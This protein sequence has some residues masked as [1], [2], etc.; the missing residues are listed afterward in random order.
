MPFTVKYAL[1]INLALEN[2]NPEKPSN[3][4]Y[5]KVFIKTETVRDKKKKFLA[6]ENF[7]QNF[8]LEEKV[9][10][11]VYAVSRT[12]DAENCQILYESLDG[13]ETWDESKNWM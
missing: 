2:Q 13:G 6:L 9:S 11:P 8:S 1:D 4:N 3:E 5:K 12:I 7:C 10:A